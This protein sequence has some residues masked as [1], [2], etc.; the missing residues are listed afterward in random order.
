MTTQQTAGQV[1]TAEIRR[2]FRINSRTRTTRNGQNLR[3]EI[4]DML[5]LANTLPGYYSEATHVA[6]NGTYGIYLSWMKH[7]DGYRIDGM[8]RYRLTSMTPW[9]F[10]A[11]LGQMLDAGVTNVGEGETFFANMS[12]ETVAA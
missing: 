4:I 2:Y 3:A 9:E 11:L 1:L 10:S 7:I 6:L 12:R 8:L 5:Q